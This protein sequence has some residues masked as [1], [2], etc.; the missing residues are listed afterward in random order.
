MSS[1]TMASQIVTSR[2][3]FITLSLIL[4]L[5][6]GC[7]IAGSSSGGRRSVPDTDSDGIP[8]HLERS[9]KGVD[10]TVDTDGDGIPDYLDTDDDNDGIPDSRDS[11]RNGD[12]IPDSRQDQDGDGIPDYLD[13]DDDGDGIVDK[14]DKKDTDGDG[15][16]D[17]VDTDDDGDGI[18]GNKNTHWHTYS[19]AYKC[20]TEL[21]HKT[22]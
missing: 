9:L 10:K 5:V 21:S 7:I 2:S 3:K 14:D 11:D 16:P 22:D 13:I 17:D 6:P 1:T 4:L 20:T 8:D 19:Q 15:I 12:G 18:P